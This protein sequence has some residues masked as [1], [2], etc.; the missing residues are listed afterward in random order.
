MPDVVVEGW[1][2]D[3]AADVLRDRVVVVTGGARG[4]GREIALLAA[5]HGAAVLVN[6]LG[7][8]TDGAGQDAGP[9]ATL[10]TEIR[11]AGG[12]AA[13]NNDSVTSAD[14][15]ARII[16]AAMDSFGR[17][18][19]V[20]NNAGIL[21]DKI[22]HRMSHEEFDSVV[23]V[24]LR[25]SF[26]VSSA[27][28]PHFRTQ[29]SGA[30][31]HM[32]STAALIGNV[33]QANYAAAKMGIVGLSRSI[34]IDM[35]KFNVRSN[36]IAPFAWSRLVN[37]MTPEA[38]ARNFDIEL[39]KTVSAE[40]VAPLAVFL[41]SDAARNITGQIFAIRKDEVFLFDQPR[42]IRQLHHAG[43]WTVETLGREMAPAFKSALTP[44]ESSADV[45]AWDAM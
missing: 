22:F 27:A 14:G 8:G 1:G 5:A 23:D 9:A 43:G 20:V 41:L 18:D 19:C 17:V 28:A 31:V 7:G 40:K 6:D 25:G 12:R 26:N 42:P 34:A 3:A 30:F 10:V 29:E 38:M 24:H 4:I 32:T 11:N 2:V 36:C 45:F 39:M 44:L 13:A 35:A 21:R 37:T 33:A 15:A 16:T